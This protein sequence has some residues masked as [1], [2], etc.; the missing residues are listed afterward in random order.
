[1]VTTTCRDD[2]GSTVHALLGCP[3]AAGAWKSAKQTIMREPTNSRGRSAIERRRCLLGASSGAARQP[4][5]NRLGM[6]HPLLRL[7]PFRDDARGGAIRPPPAI[8][9]FALCILRASYCG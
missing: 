6:L 9:P 2:S 7:A 5:R 8:S 1:M 3:V 4:T